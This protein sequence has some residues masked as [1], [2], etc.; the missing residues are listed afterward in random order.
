M[1]TIHNKQQSKLTKL[2]NEMV[3]QYNELKMEQLVDKSK[4]KICEH[5]N[6]KECN[7]I[8]NNIYLRRLMLGDMLYELKNLK[9]K[10]KLSNREYQ[11]NKVKKYV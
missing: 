4:I 10:I 1:A 11:I 2:Y 5:S 6:M 9:Y 7:D 8:C 3:K